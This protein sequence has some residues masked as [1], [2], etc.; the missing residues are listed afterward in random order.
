MR[1][2]SRC[3]QTDNCRLEQIPF[4]GIR[5]INKQNKELR[6]SESGDWEAT[7]KV[8]IEVDGESIAIICNNAGEATILKFM[9]E[10]PVILGKNGL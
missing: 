2:T 4:V 10:N 6:P 8:D 7:L 1:K 3:Y 5:T 9:L